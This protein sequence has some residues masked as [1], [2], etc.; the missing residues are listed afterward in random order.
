MTV[1][2]H[3]H[4]LQVGDHGRVLP[5]VNFWSLELASWL[6]ALEPHLLHLGGFHL[7]VSARHEG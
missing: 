5:L 3:I 4:Y 6:L 7:R 1:I 2:Y